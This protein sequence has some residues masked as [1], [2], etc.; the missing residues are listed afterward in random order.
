MWKD[1]K[2]I[3]SCIVA[4]TDDNEEDAAFVLRIKNLAFFSD[5]NQSCSLHWCEIATENGML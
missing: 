3:P 5:H 1:D 2:T 4:V